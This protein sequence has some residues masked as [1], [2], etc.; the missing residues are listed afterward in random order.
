M[1]IS[2]SILSADFAHLQD[3]IH[4][5]EQAGADMI[6]VDVMDGHFVPN[7]TIGPLIVEAARR[8][9]HLPVDVHLMVEEPDRLIHEFIEAGASILTVH[10][11][12]CVHLQ[13]TLAEIRSLGARPGVALCPSTPVS[14]LEHVI[15]DVELLLIMTVNPG[16]AAQELIPATI[17]KVRRAR[18]LLSTWQSNAMIE[19][20]GGINPDTA[21]QLVEA[22]AE[23]LV[24]GSAI[25]GNGAIEAN[26]QRLRAAAS[27]VATR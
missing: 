13:R 27:L 4:R 14:L 10:Q 22:G 19:V 6:H 11:E 18:E 23:V 12:A 9:T 21:P 7:L 3:Q 25:F 15:D 17:G 26:V 8:S 5:A 16:F 24:A 2:A 1:Q 20:D